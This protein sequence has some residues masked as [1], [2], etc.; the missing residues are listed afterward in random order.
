MQRDEA[1]DYIASLL[2]SLREVAARADLAFLAY[3]IGIAV[4]EA[5]A[6]KSRSGAS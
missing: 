4:D 2:E 5:K 6:Q 3:L 1:V